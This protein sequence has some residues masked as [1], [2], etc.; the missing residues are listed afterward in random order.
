ME[1]TREDIFVTVSWV[2]KDI[3]EKNHI[4][5]DKEL[6]RIV[7]LCRACWESLKEKPQRDDYYWILDKTIENG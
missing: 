2:L 6:P 7:K 4:K 5:S 1:T 3:L